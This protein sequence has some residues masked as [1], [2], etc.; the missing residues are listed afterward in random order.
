MNDYFI[1]T[2]KNLKPSTVPNTSDIDEITKY[3]DDQ[4]SVCKM[5]EAYSE[6]L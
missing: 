6:I 1:N 5:N 3:C 4:I 2:T